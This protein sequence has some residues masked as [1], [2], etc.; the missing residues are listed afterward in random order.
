M[1][2]TH[3]HCRVAGRNRWRPVFYYCFC[4]CDFSWETIIMQNI[5]KAFGGLLAWIAFMKLE[6]IIVT[7]RLLWSLLLRRSSSGL[8]DAPHR[9]LSCPGRIQKTHPNS[10]GTTELQSGVTLPLSP[11]LSGLRHRS[12]RLTEALLTATYTLC[13]AFHPHTLLERKC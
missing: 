2:H 9:S 7:S 12:P 4:N 5:L 3:T 11:R 13:P 8:W 1:T 10:H 6:E